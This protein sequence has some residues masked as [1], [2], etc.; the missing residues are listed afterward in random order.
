MSGQT[1]PPLSPRLQAL[2]EAILAQKQPVRLALCGFDLWLELL[3]SGHTWM[4]EFLPGGQI[5]TE[6]DKN[7]PIKV[8]V[9]VIGNRT[10]ISFDPTL[11][12]DRFSLKL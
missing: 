12:P 3:S 5:A 8:P 1:P 10:V 7:R 11:P 6:A 9:M 2:S 4:C